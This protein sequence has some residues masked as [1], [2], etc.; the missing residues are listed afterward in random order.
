VTTKSWIE[1][2]PGKQQ[3]LSAK[4]MNTGR[5]AAK[6]PWAQKDPRSKRSV[7]RWVA[8]GY[9][10]T[11]RFITI[12]GNRY[13]ILEPMGSFG[14]IAVH[15]GPVDEWEQSIEGAEKLDDNLYALDIDPDSFENVTTRIKA[16]IRPRNFALSL[17][18][19]PAIPLGNFGNDYQSGFSVIADVGYQVHSGLWSLGLFGYNYFPAT[20]SGLDD[21][22]W[23]NISANLRYYLPL[24]QP[25]SVYL[26]GGVGLYIPTTGDLAFGLNAG[27]GL[28]YDISRLVALE[29]GAEYHYLFGVDQ[30]Q[31]MTVPVGVILRF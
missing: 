25:L 14:H 5:L 8:H 9:L 4:L 7:L 31:F 6:I 16:I 26:G 10:E 17:H 29:A 28:R 12:N 11:G 3:K 19:G 21:S 18:A 24:Y 30:T 23:I 27:A 2:S 15:E 1:K 22:H 13:D 20:T